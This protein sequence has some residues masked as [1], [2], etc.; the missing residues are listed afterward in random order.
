MNPVD[1]VRQNPR[2]KALVKRSLFL[3]IPPTPLHRLLLV[4]RTLRRHFFSEL[5]RI[6]YY[7]PMFELQCERVG[8]GT[9]LEMMPDSK[10]PVL[11]NCELVLG[12]R[13]R[14]NART[15]MTGAVAAPS[16]VRIEIGDDVWIGPG[17][18]VRAGLGL[19]VGARTWIANGAAL[20][21]DP[22]HPLDPVARHTLPAP[23]ES[24]GFQTIGEDV[25]IAQGAMVLGGVTIGDGAVIGAHAVV[26][27]D[28]PP[29]TLVAGNPARVI[30]KIE[31][32]KLEAA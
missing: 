18:V 25:W 19:R 22:G 31:S 28:V 1:F 17:V 5:T 7:Q 16:K 29:R 26:T 10:I 2:L 15:T 30:R 4:E 27:K 3:R 9:R 14:L 13:V 12:S 20:A 23:R 32:P 24:L 21:G 6:V 8:P 11:I